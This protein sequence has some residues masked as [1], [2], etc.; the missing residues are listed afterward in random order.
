MYLNFQLI[1]PEISYFIVLRNSIRNNNETKTQEIR[2]SVQL[3]E[4]H[5]F[6]SN[7]Y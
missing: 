4:L 7:Y 6:F 1:L 5:G 3:T 2:K